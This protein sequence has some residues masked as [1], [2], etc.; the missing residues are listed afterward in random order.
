MCNQYIPTK[1]NNTI[2]CDKFKYINFLFY[3]RDIIIT[4]LFNILV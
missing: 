1:L 2:N 3:T 4:R